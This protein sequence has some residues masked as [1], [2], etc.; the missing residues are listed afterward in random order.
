M[1]EQVARSSSS[2]DLPH[3]GSTCIGRRV[4]KWHRAK[5]LTLFKT[6]DLGAVYSLSFLNLCN[7][8]IVVISPRPQFL[9]GK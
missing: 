2:R 1:L 3:Q 5:S 4:P 7:L 6:D 9:I 8:D